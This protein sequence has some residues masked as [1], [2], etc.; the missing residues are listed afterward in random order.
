MAAGEV[1]GTRCQLVGAGVVLSG[2]C[3]DTP[4]SITSRSTGLSWPAHDN[5]A[6]N[7]AR[8]AQNRRAMANLKE[9]VP[10]ADDNPCRDNCYNALAH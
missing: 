1:T 8:R 2:A 3:T 9:A 6:R 5:A 4:T 7:G 10:D